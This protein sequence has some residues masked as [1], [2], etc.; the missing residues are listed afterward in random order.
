MK[1]MF[2]VILF[3]LPSVIIAQLGRGI[4]FESGMNWE[5]IKEYAKRSNK[6]IFVDA[7]TTWCGPCKKMDKEVYNNDSVGKYLNEKY[8]SIKLQIDSTTQDSPAVR[9][10]YSMAGIF[11][12]QYKITEYPSYLFFSSEGIL[13]YRDRGFKNVE[14]F[15]KLCEEALNRENI[16]LSKE[17][18][19]YKSGIAVPTASLLKL[20]KYTKTLGD[21]QLSKRIASEYISVTDHSEL[22]DIEKIY[23]IYDYASNKNLADSLANQYKCTILE[24]SDDL[25]ILSRVNLIFLSR[26]PYILKSKDRLFKIFYQYPKK[27]DSVLGISDFATQTLIEIIQK[28]ELDNKF[29]VK[30]EPVI[31]TPNWTALTKQLK[32]KYPKINCK[33][34]VLDYK[35]KYYNQLKDWPNYCLALIEKVE[36][37]GAFGPI[38]VVDFNLNN[39]AWDLFEHA[40]GAHELEVALKW[41]D[42]AISLCK[43]SNKPNWMDTKANILYK[44]GRIN[45]AIDLE[46]QAILLDPKHIDFQENLKKMKAGRPTWTN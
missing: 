38:P 22:L 27:I 9:K 24:K 13:I 6:Y 35:V 30:A 43:N 14:R 40:S 8:I 28:E 10:R 26:F 7:Y 32:K 29:I 18:Q 12:D 11:M 39:L 23:F 2:L 20:A 15:V 42:S 4:H 5:E 34:I 33:F 31:K 17:L 16:S 36:N 3:F 41:S 21:L 44:L 46:N 1:Y 37:Y 19:V 45:E 25:Q